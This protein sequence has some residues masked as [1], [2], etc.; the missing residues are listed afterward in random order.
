MRRRSCS[1]Y[2]GRG[3][4][5]NLLECRRG[6]YRM[7][8]ADDIRHELRQLLEVTSRIDERVRGLV[9]RQQELADAIQA[10]GEQ[11]TDVSRRLALVE[12]TGG[13]SL[14]ELRAEVRV[15]DRQLVEIEHRVKRL[16]GT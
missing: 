13:Q 11:L 8:T 10:Q 12:V 16:E 4:F 5:M 15:I 9:E 6:S 1:P 3:R 7:P 14:V 2:P